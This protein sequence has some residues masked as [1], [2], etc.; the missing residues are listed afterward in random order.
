VGWLSLSVLGELTFYHAEGDT[1]QTW[2]RDEDLPAGT[3]IND[4]PYEIESLQAR[5]GITL[6][7]SF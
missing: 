1:D 7:A 3:Q 5:I 6:G 4:I 2:Y